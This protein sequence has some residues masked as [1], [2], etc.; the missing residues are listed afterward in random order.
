MSTWKKN[1]RGVAGTSCSGKQLEAEAQTR[2]LGS[3]TCRHP[4]AYQAGSLGLFAGCWVTLAVSPKSRQSVPCQR[5]RPDSGMG[6]EDAPR[7]L[8]RLR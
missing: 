4:L 3:L 2:R 5:P 6:W 8:G 7:A 1:V